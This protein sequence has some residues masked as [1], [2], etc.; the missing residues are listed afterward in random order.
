[1]AFSTESLPGQKHLKITITPMMKA[2]VVG[3]HGLEVSSVPRPLMDAEQILV[4]VH[5]SALN[6]ADLAMAMAAGHRHGQAGGAGA[7]AGLEWAGEVVNAAPAAQAYMAANQHFG[8]ILLA[9]R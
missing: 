1:M 8:K 3:A 2:A 5:S 7:V 4:Q 6:R 9:V